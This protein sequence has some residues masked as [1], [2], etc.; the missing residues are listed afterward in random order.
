M[1]RP[2][3]EQKYDAI[4]SA[5]INIIAEQGLGAPTV[6][7]AAIAGVSHGSIFNY[8]KNKTDLL[9]SVYLGLTQ[10]LSRIVE[11]E[12]PLTGTV[13]EQLRHVWWRWAHWGAANP[14][15]PQTLAQLA[16]SDQITDDSRG[17]AWKHAATPIGIFDK[18]RI[19]GTLR[20][21]PIEFVFD[22]V[23]AVA[24]ATINAMIRDPAA[25]DGY[26]STSF[27]ALWNALTSPVCQEIESAPPATDLRAAAGRPARK[28][29]RKPV[30]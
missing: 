11:E 27:D 25:A 30:E 12:L 8:F 14:A 22:I 7:I 13:H 5:T 16:V 26:C 29:R 9:N 21:Q 23:N 24:G 19:R 1:A 2:K 18:A 10:E 28:I 15:K 17:I 6:K 3:S 20:D 4:I